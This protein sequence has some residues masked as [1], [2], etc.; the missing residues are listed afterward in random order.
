M[1]AGIAQGCPVSGSIFAIFSHGI[2]ELLQQT[3]APAPDVATMAEDTPA[4]L[5][6]YALLR[7]ISRSLSAIGDAPALRVKAANTV[8]LPLWPAALAPGTRGRPGPG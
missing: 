8:L 6:H 5:R 7:P 3:V 2:V 4:V 1:E